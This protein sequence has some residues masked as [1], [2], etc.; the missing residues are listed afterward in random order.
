MAGGRNSAVGVGGL[1]LGGKYLLFAFVFSFPLCGSESEARPSLAFSSFHHS[2]SDLRNN[3]AIS[4]SFSHVS[5]WSA[6]TFCAMNLS[7]P[8][9]PL[10]QLLH[11]RIW[12]FER[13]S[14]AASIT[15][16]LSTVNRLAFP[17]RTVRLMPTK[18]DS[19]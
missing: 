11:Q 19:A 14:K 1:A 16:T 10:L 5:A 2:K 7:S 13:L 6:P 15:L 12:T 18:F 3:Q 9:V 4:P 8:P 17:V